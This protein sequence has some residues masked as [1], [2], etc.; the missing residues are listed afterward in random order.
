MSP[1]AMYFLS[2]RNLLYQLSI[3]WF[4]GTTSCL[5]Y[6]LVLSCSSLVG[7]AREVLHTS[8]YSLLEAIYVYVY[9]HFHV[10]PSVLKRTTFFR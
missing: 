4:G 3:I 5:V 6:A 10:L 9:D 2:S 7:A 8:Y 1:R